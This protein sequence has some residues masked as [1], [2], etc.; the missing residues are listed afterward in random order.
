MMTNGDISQQHLNPNTQPNN[1]Q[2]ALLHQCLAFSSHQ[3]YGAGNMGNLP[4]LPNL[5]T[6]PQVNNPSG[7][8]MFPDFS[9]TNPYYYTH[10]PNLNQSSR[11]A[12]TI[13]PI[14]LK[15]PLNGSLDTIRDG[16][17]QTAAS[18]TDGSSPFD[19]NG[20]GG[21]GNN[22]FYNQIFPVCFLKLFLSCIL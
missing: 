2:S 1:P 10:Q 16:G 4:F 18:S 20:S 15:F 22:A 14:D 7:Q 5:S 17:A 8:P 3:Q 11:P 6:H 12:P 13:S 9:S 19:A 21:I